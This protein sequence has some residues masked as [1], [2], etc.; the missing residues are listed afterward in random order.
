MAKKETKYVCLIYKPK[1]KRQKL[2]CFTEQELEAGLERNRKME[3][4]AEAKVAPYRVGAHIGYKKAGKPKQYKWTWSTSDFYVKENGNVKRVTGDSK[5]IPHH[6]IPYIVEHA[7]TWVK[8]QGIIKMVTRKKTILAQEG[9]TF[10]RYFS[11]V[12][13]IDFI[14]QK[15][16]KKKGW[17]FY[18]QG[19][20]GKTKT[21]KNF[22][23]KTACIRAIEKKVYG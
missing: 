12:G 14:C 15:R 19:P 3:A 13:K 18:K 8:E 17:E 6:L 10:V 22:P 16:W 11:G 23:S 21:T 7:G 4:R 2:A 9:K 1:D 5:A 20:H